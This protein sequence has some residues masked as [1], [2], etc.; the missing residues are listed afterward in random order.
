M[1]FGF[2]YSKLGHNY[3]TS[4]NNN[5]NSLVQ[6]LGNLFHQFSRIE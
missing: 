6:D 1:H 4:F 3:Q 5:A 2:T